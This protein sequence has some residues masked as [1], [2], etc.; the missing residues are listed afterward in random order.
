MEGTAPMKTLTEAQRRRVA[1]INV[2]IARLRREQAGRVRAGMAVFLAIVA[3]F[4]LA[5]EAIGKSHELV[6]PPKAAVWLPMLPP[7]QAGFPR[8][9]WVLADVFSQLPSGEIENWLMRLAGVLSLVF[10]GLATR[11]AWVDNF[12]RKPPV[13]DAIET[14]RKQL[15]GL[16]PSAKV[17]KLI[18]QIGSAATRE[19][20]SK[21]M[22]LLMEKERDLGAQIK[23][24]RAYAHD[25]VHTMRA[26]LQASLLTATAR[27]DRV[28]Q[29][30][31]ALS[32]DMSRERS[33]S[34]AKI[35]ERIEA[36]SNAQRAEFEAKLRIVHEDITGLPG[37]LLTLLQQTG[38]IGRGGKA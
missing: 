26:E 18:E 8:D 29:K 7:V 11:R 24:G 34:V 28:T 10:L 3:L 2:E 20:L 22:T 13:D 5:P 38:Q 1:E 27:E 25:S 6:P 33:A 9:G 32:K 16:A 17:D 31:E 15:D 14:L 35:H 12:G 19:E 4:I 37:R 36:T 23:E 30:I 21:V